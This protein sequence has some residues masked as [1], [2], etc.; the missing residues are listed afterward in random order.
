[1]FLALFFFSI[2]ILHYEIMGY[3]PY[4]RQAGA[5]LN[6]ERI[7]KTCRNTFA[8]LENRSLLHKVYV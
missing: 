3:P 6:I 4:N 2:S 1:M 7:I 5:L 8:Q